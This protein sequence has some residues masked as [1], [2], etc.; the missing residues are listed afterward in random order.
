MS[1]DAPV[2]RIAPPG[3]LV[4]P[5]LTALLGALGEAR[6]VGG[7]V[8]DTLLGLPPGDLDLATPLEPQTVVERLTRAGIRTMP[9]GIAHGT[10][11][12]VLAGGRPVEITTLRRDVETDGRHATVA[13]TADWAADAARRD[14]TMNALYLD[15]TG[16]IWDPMQGLDDCAA[17]RVRFVGAPLR[18]IDEDVLRIPRFYRFQARYGRVPADPAARA[19]CRAR[20][21][22]IDGLAGERLQ[23][24]TRKLL[25]AE[26]PTPTVRLMIVDD[27]LGAY[28][29]APFVVDRLAAL[30]E[31]EPKADWI[32]R[33]AAML[34]DGTAA[35]ERL[36][37]SNADRHRLIRLTGPNPID[38]GAGTR[39]QRVMLYRL[40]QPLYRDFALLGGA[41]HLL[42]IAEG[43]QNPTLPVG[44]GDV[45][46][47]GIPAGPRVGALLRQVEA[48]WIEGD[49]Q[50]DRAA[51][52]DRLGALA[53]LPEV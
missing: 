31:I 35:A 38:P 47:F 29:P 52:L 30:V 12:A 34:D 50:A 1:A 36:R 8:R 25:M 42:T 9:T 26:D 15:R 5:A 44:G 3:W 27:V 32:R 23:T 48:W 49:F 22:R 51:C 4:D 7:V 43:W 46:A 41:Q 21:A 16:G 17:G 14:F 53:V 2:R 40:G 37:L 18:R 39:A 45:T 11:T 33:L 24:E 13:F 20:A 10:V 19:A 28:L 6:F